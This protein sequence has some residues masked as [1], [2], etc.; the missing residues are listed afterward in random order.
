[1]PVQLTDEEK[2]ALFNAISPGHQ[3][4]TTSRDDG[5][6]MNAFVEVI[7]KLLSSLH[8]RQKTNLKP[9]ERNGLAA[10]DARLVHTYQR[11]GY[12]NGV[13]KSYCDSFREHSVSLENIGGNRVV[14]ALQGVGG[15]S[16]PANINNYLPPQVNGK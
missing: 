8:L 4:V 6:Q 7:D 16:P 9:N 3:D 1:M 10:L 15:S 14:S 5:P 12:V 2:K 13:L 11:K